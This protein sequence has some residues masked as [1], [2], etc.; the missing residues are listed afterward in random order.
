MSHIPDLYVTLLSLLHV[1][2]LLPRSFSLRYLQ[3]VDIIR[4]NQFAG[5]STLLARILNIDN[6][7]NIQC[8]IFTG[9]NHDGP[10]IFKNEYPF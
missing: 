2:P 7:G 6:T 5:G 4:D 3:Y 1:L 10:D 8:L 9:Q